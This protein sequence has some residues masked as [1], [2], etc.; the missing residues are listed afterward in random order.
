M[1]KKKDVDLQT[2]INKFD[3]MLELVENLRGSFNIICDYLDE[4]WKVAGFP[5]GFERGKGDNVAKSV[6]LDK[7]S[8]MNDACVD[9]LDKICNLAKSSVGE[10]EY[11]R[12]LATAWADNAGIPDK[13]YVLHFYV[14][15]LF[16]KE[17]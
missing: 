9:M 2:S 15:E 3:S 11:A 1:N 14:H 8:T 7:F 13:K 16:F 10:L 6:D 5:G 4:T 17:A 12:N